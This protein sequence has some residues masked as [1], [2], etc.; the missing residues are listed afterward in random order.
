M[1]ESAG[2]VLLIDTHTHLDDAAFD[3]DRDEVVAAARAIGVCRFINIAYSPER[4]QSSAELRVRFP[5]T[6]IAVGLHPQIAH[7]LSSDLER[8]LEEAVNTLR[9]VAIGESGFDLARGDSTIEDQRRAFQ[10]QIALAT[11]SGLP[12]VIHQRQASDELIA[13]LDRWPG[14]AAIVL[15]SFDGTPR[16]ARWAAERGCYIGVGGLAARDS[17]GALR[18][19]LKTTPAD[20][21]LLETDSPYLAPPGAPRRNTPAALPLIANR[22]APLWNLSTEEMCRV[23]TENA[24]RLFAL[25]H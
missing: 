25:E 8:D 19:L 15:H 14:L 24:C 10:F 11:A 16:L 5:E 3:E 2:Q 12:L 9:P 4:W 23:T 18:S 6:A 1:T 7:R 21:L 22:L 13:E 17:S 20:R